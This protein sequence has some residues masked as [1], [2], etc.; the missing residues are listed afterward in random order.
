MLNLISG[1]R[2]KDCEGT[3]RRD[4]I[5]VGA[6]GLAIGGVILVAAVGCTVALIHWECVLFA[7]NV[8]N[9]FCESNS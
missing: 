3:T 6:L 9:C 5:K 2:S 1:R 7:S 4:F 8:E